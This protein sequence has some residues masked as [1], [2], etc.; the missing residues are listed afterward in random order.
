MHAANVKNANLEAAIPTTGSMIPADWWTVPVRALET[1]WSSTMKREVGRL[2]VA[3]R[4]EIALRV[5]RTAHEMGI[6]TIAIYGD[7]EENARHVQYANEAW[8]IG[9]GDGLPYLRIP[10][11]IEIAKSAN[12]DAVHPGYGFLA[13]NAG[14][15]RAVRDA[16]ITFIGPTAESMEQLGD[17]I[18]ARKLALNAGV[19]P[20]PGTEDAVDTIDEARRVAED[21]GYPIAVKA[22]AGGGGRGFRVAQSP[23]DLQT[24]FDGARGEADRYFANPDVFLE[25]YVANPRHIEVQIFVDAEG[26]IIAFPER[27]CSI[28]RR[29]QKL[30]EETPSTAVSPELRAMLQ[31]ASIRLAQTADYKNVGTIEYLL[32]EDDSFYF[33]EVNTRVQVEHTVTE[34]VTGYDIVREQLRAAN[35]MPSSFESDRLEPYGWSIECRINAEDAADDF[36]PHPNTLSSVVRPIGFGVRVDS[37][38]QTGDTIS[39]KYDSLIS[40]VITWGRTRDE[41]ISRMVRSLDDYEIVGAPS[42]IPFHQQVLKTE[43]FLTGQTF[44]SFLAKH[45]DDI[46]AAISPAKVDEI[47][48]DEESDAPMPLLI[49]VD[50]HRFDVKVFGAVTAAAPAKKKAGKKRKRAAG[51]AAHGH[52][53]RDLLSPGQGTVLRVAVEVGQTVAV[54]DLIC[55]LESMKMENEIVSRRDGV[56]AAVGITQ[57]QSVGRGELLAS[58]DPQ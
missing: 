53:D 33:M 21:I 48:E 44:T 51:A 25:R 22:T 28:Q 47:S 57:G 18:S 46:V 54:G 58:I 52:D 15:V 35:G 17:K 40:K 34:M 56:V 30:V 32:D 37:A 38:L 42:T 1:G 16:G 31:D 27:E 20:V 9:D 26:R 50:G 45:N 2:L 55:V 23:D 11:I 6:H 7:D 8:R 3:N 14:F 29:H 36:R 43:D 41:A 24:A 19:S 39:D 4:G 12:A 13:E 49:E 5:M 10:Q